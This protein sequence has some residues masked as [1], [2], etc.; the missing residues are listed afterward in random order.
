MILSGDLQAAQNCW[1][2][3][4]FEEWK[5]SILVGKQGEEAFRIKK[6]HQAE[7]DGY[8]ESHV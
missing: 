7:V 6:S 2:E 3:G 1:I 8:L 5:I 4:M